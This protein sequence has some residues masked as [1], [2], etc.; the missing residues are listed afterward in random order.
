M[1]YGSQVNKRRC[2]AMVAAGIEDP[3]S[4]EGML[5]CAGSRDDKVKSQ[6]PYD[7]CVVFED[8]TSTKQKASM[9]ARVARELK[10][11][12]VTVEDIALILHTH[13]RTVLRYLK[14]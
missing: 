12:Q 14:K 2:P 13:T 9:R 5:F 1:N 3:D 11:H 7:F 10:K 4:S 6:C 8:E